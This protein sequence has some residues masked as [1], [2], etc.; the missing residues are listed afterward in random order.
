MQAVLSET[1]VSVAVDPKSYN[2]ALPSISR[3]KRRQLV[4]CSSKRKNFLKAFGVGPNVVWLSQEP[5]E[6]RHTLP[7]NLRLDSHWYTFSNS[8]D[9]GPAD[10]MEHYR[11]KKN[12]KVL[13]L[14]QKHRAIYCYLLDVSKLLYIC[15]KMLFLLTG[16]PTSWNLVK[17]DP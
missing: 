6:R 10:I 12:T 15:E 4:I 13:C 14:L 2:P 9:T 3:D 11:I 7:A 5:D 17:P 1:Y 16:V 8:L